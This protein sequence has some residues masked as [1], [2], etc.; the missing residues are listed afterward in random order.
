MQ[1]PRGANPPPA[2]PSDV[3]APDQVTD[4]R[5]ESAVGAPEPDRPGLYR[6]CD[7]DLWLKT[8]QGWRLCLQRDVTVD[9][10]SVWQWIDGHVRDYAPFVPIFPV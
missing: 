4:D 9:P 2:L 6:D 8:G 7:G 3:Y 1:T 10:A 5:T